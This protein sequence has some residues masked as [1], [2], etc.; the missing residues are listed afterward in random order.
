MIEIHKAVE[1]PQIEIVR[2]LF[3]EYAASIVFDLSVQDFGEELAGLPGDYAR[4]T[5]CLL[6]AV[7]G[8]EPAGCV[9]LR[10]IGDGVSEMKRLYV[11]P[12]FRG[13]RLGRLLAER[14]IDE[15]RTLGYRCM[16]LDTLEGMTEAQALY[17]SLGFR[18]VEAYRDY[19]VAGVL[20]ME[21]D[22]A[23]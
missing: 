18:R 16:R 5:G 1:P 12:A 13:H 6:L 19:P 4:P 20:F 15:A 2:G 22:L 10:Q 17:G 8:D 9:A 7:D 23:N 14:I 21:L 3:R 11:R